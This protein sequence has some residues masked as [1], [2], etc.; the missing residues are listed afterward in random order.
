MNFFFLFS[1]RVIKGHK[2]IIA[3][4]FLV[5]KYLGTF[6]SVDTVLCVGDTD[7]QDKALALEDFLV[8]K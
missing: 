1:F 2:G 4:Y 6:S 3:A 7:E 8:R 5:S